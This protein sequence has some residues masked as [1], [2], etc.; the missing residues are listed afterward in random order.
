MPETIDERTINIAPSNRFHITENLNLAI[1]AAKGI[2]LT[3]VNIG[4][5]DLIEGK[6]HLVLGL[7]WQAHTSH[8]MNVTC[9]TR[10]TYATH[11]RGLSSGRWSR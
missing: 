7:V 6:P 9:V 5:A 8:V 1:N 3:V 4:A 10:V 11:V 2:G